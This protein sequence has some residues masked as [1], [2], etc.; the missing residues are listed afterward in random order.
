MRDSPRPRYGAGRPPYT[1]VEVAFQHAVDNVQLPEQGA[2]RPMVLALTAN[3]M[4][5][6]DERCRAAGMDG[7]L[8]KP[9]RLK[10]LAEALAPLARDRS[11]A[12]S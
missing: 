8:A 10:A 12:K 7:Y 5:G 11:A 4:S 3:V 1:A 9:L 6:D 2:A